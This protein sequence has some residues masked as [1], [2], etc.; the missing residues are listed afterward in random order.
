MAQTG[1]IF[2]HS[3]FRCA[4][5]FFFQ[6]F[7]AL[8]T[9]YT[10]YQEPFNESLEAL[11][12]PARHARLL[13]PPDGAP[14]RHPQLDKPYFHEFW[15]RRWRLQGLYRRTFAYHEYFAGS[16]LPAPQ[17]RWIT[18]LL[19]QANGRAVLQFCRSSGRAAALREAFGGVH[20]HLWRE[21]RSQWWSYKIADYFDSVSRR[22]YE[23]PG[24]PV[25][26]AQLRQE[27]I[28]HT[29]VALLSAWQ[30][31][32]LYYGL[33]LYS[34]LALS[35]VADASISV[36]RIALSAAENRACSARLAGLLGESID[37]TDIRASGM[38]F[39]P[40]E[41]QLYE[42]VEQRVGALIVGSGQASAARVGAAERAAA[43]VRLAHAQRAHDASAERNLRQ[44]ALAMMERMQREGWKPRQ[45]RYATE[46]A[47]RSALLDML[48]RVW[49]GLSGPGATG[50]LSE[51][52]R[53]HSNAPLLLPGFGTE[54]ARNGYH[55]D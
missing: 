19:A 45:S 54:A 23:A 18:A 30:N 8:G 17:Q 1:P 28:G 51:P 32:A 31:Y 26:L 25:P 27:V 33:W 35:D 20:L 2:I 4:S 22:I 37:L 38:A 49:S 34:W 48:H 15:L 55:R 16:T 39:A 5:T 50:R 14:L 13:A 10:C 36:D 40:E 24:L 29:T 46:G 53:L 52:A 42:S 43:D 6:K 44:A 41:L 3:L 9:D 12:R 7:R 21:P 11:N 47:A